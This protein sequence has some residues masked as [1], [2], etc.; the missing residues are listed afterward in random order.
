MAETESARNF[1]DTKE[2]KTL[3]K[4]NQILRIKLFQQALANI[5]FSEILIMHAHALNDLTHMD[6]KRRN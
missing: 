1:L 2:R 3:S 6:P 5:R 4:I